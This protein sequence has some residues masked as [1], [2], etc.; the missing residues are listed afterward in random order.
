MEDWHAVIARSTVCKR[1]NG[2]D[3]ELSL[4]PTLRPDARASD[5]NS[6]PDGACV[7]RN[8]PGDPAMPRQPRTRPASCVGAWFG[9][10]IPERRCHWPPAPK[11][12]QGQTPCL[13]RQG[14]PA[15]PW[16]SRERGICP[17]CSAALCRAKLDGRG[18]AN[19]PARGDA[20]MQ[21]Q[22]WMRPARRNSSGLPRQSCARPGTIERLQAL[23]E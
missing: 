4:Y 9:P 12:R 20:P 15:L 14:R 18:M 17:R 7:L 19:F 1:P 16:V 8:G 21:A 23:T 22:S 3:P 10:S 11:G 6:A 13:P 2:A 5:P